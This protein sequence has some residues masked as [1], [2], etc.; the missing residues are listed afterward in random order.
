MPIRPHCGGSYR[1]RQKICFEKRNSPLAIGGSRY[2][3]YCTGGVVRPEANQCPA[4]G[5]KKWLQLK[6]LPPGLKPKKKLFRAP[7]VWA[8]LTIFCFGRENHVFFVPARVPK[9][10]S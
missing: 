1:V 10:R 9:S 8:N 4:L 2:S 7:R 6:G 5:K 3:S